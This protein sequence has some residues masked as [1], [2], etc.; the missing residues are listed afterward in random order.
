MCLPFYGSSFINATALSMDEV[1]NLS[2]GD[3]VDLRIRIFIALLMDS[4]VLFMQFLILWLHIAADVV[5]ILDVSNWIILWF[6]SLYL[7]CLTRRSHLDLRSCPQSLH[8]VFGSVGTV[9][10]IGT[11]GALILY[12]DDPVDI[13]YRWWALITLAIHYMMSIVF[14][15][16]TMITI[17]EEDDIG[18]GTARTTNNTLN[19][20]H[21][22]NTA[23]G[24]NTVHNHVV[25]IGGD[26]DVSL[27]GCA[28]CS[29]ATQSD[30]EFFNDF[31]YGHAALQMEAASNNMG[32]VK[33]NGLSAS[34]DSNG[35]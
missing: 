21:A 1:M 33:I 28:E 2:V 32:A 35:I 9:H 27:D 7:F 34:T 3:Q 22:A 17:V 25:N 4:G 31:D 16:C 14:Y 5:F 6:L 18:N 13:R 19:T 24:A 12:L 26:H 23:N 20:V 11:T 29:V 8:L 30:S 10:I 15:V